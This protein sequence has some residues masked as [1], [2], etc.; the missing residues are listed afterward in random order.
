MLVASLVIF[1]PV[2]RDRGT[3]SV[4]SKFVEFGG[5]LVRVT[6]HGSLILGSGFSLEAAPF[7][8]CAILNNQ[9]RLAQSIMLALFEFQNATP[10]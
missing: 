5:S 2:V 8:R 3:V 1:F 4:R 9:C 6:W 10:G 7:G